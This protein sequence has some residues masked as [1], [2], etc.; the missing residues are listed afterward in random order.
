MFH[1]LIINRNQNMMA[2]TKQIP[3]NLHVS[4]PTTAIGSDGPT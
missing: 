2:H 3:R 4:R 1:L